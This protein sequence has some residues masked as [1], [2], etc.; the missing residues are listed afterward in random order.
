[1]VYRTKEDSLVSDIN[2]LSELPLEKLLKVKNTIN[3]ENQVE[4]D[5]FKSDEENVSPVKEN[6]GQQ[7]LHS[8]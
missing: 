4:S 2:S 8:K 7:A 1:M 3:L 6:Y 5:L